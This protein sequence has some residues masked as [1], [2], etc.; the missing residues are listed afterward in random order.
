M[1]RR[2]FAS[3]AAAF[4]LDPERALWVPGAK[5]I[6][7]PK[8]APF[9]CLVWEDGTRFEAGVAIINYFRELDRLNMLPRLGD[10]LDIPRP[11]RFVPYSD[12]GAR[13]MP[14][15]CDR[16]TIT[17]GMVRDLNLRIDG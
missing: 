10:T 14:R 16:V 9:R 7:V 13:T 15:L 5:T 8:P 17:P 4:A 11:P 1:T 2:V 3:L 12:W 6:S